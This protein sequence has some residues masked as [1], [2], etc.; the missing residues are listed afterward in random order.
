MSLKN[1]LFTMFEKY[2]CN[3]IYM[4]KLINQKTRNYFFST[5]NIV[6]LLILL[7]GKNR[8]II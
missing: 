6:P 3:S 4:M 7:L 5:Q 1:I 2:S 8:F